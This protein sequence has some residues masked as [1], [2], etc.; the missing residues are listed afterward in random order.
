MGR[1][2][3]DLYYH[4]YLKLDR[5]LSSQELE[6]AAAGDTVHDEMLFIIV[7]QAYELWFKEILWELD[8]VMEAFGGA[9][10]DERHTGRVVSRL[11]RVTTIQRIL[12]DQIDVLETMTPMDFLDFRDYLVPA[13][14]F[15][16]VQFRLIENRLG[17]RPQDRLLFEGAP[18][19]HRLR[20]AHREE[21]EASEHQPS[22][23]GAVDSWLARTPFLDDYSFWDAYQDSVRA[24]LEADMKTVSA[25]PNLTGPEREDQLRSFETTMSQFEAAF[26][27][28]RHQEM[29]AAGSRKMSYRAFQAAM[30]ISLYRDEPAL[31]EPYRLLELLV[32]VD[33]GFTTWRYR[34]ALMVQRMIGARTGTG[35]SA[36]A[37]Y[38]L[39]LAERS[40]AFS[41]L[42]VL[43]TF[44]VPAST[45]P[46]LPEGLTQKM[47][48]R[49]QE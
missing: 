18:Y 15:Q 35:G 14:G 12:L 39:K 34:H 33:E 30:F 9:S 27:P 41:D 19:T 47:R 25:N 43:P 45:R 31:Q 24:T 7:H 46:A 5:L 17:V 36:G 22:L 48:F 8:D 37:K 32:E 21:V 38:L 2:E 44:M 11:R 29:V 10:F 1:N 49:Y 23:L 42:L 6:S 20:P 16:S 13:S 3:D 26:D 28:Q 4:D 40:R